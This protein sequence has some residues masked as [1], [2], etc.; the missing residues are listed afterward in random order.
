MRWY[1]VEFYFSCRLRVVTPF[2]MDAQFN[3]RD[4]KGPAMGTRSQQGNWNL[5][6]K[7]FLSKYRECLANL[8]VPG[9]PFQSGR[10]N[11]LMQVCLVDMTTLH[12]P[13]KIFVF[14]LI[15]CETDLRILILSLLT[16]LPI[17]SWQELSGLFVFLQTSGFDL[18]TASCM[19]NPS[20]LSCYILILRSCKK[21]NAFLN[22][23]E[24]K[25]DDC[26]F[27]CYIS[28]SNSNSAVSGQLVPWFRFEKFTERNNTTE[29]VNG[30]FTW[31]AVGIQSEWAYPK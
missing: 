12:W 13:S 26:I 14:C 22:M 23:W 24:N 27:Y 6:L 10:R 31:K 20:D 29:N 8:L 28:F 30:L 17:I 25:R 19:A 1:L 9:F 7:Q 16:A 5:K 21:N 11:T 3:Y 2:G 15:Y 18:F 4:Y